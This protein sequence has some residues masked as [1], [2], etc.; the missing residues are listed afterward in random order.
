MT[1]RITP[2]EIYTNHHKTNYESSKKEIEIKIIKF[3]LRRPTPSNS[4]KMTSNN[5]E[6]LNIQSEQVVYTLP[7]TV[8]K[9]LKRLR[10]IKERNTMNIIYIQTHELPHG[11]KRLRDKEK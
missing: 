7:I 8:I 3:I 1:I 6:N 5:L 10:E 11:I 2:K 9:R 4:K